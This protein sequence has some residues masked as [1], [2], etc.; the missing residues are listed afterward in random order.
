LLSDSG[1]IAGWVGAIHQA[2]Q[3]PLLGFGF[4][5]ED[6]VFI[7]RYYTLQGERPEESWIGLYLQLG[8]V[9]VVLLAALVGFILLRGAAG[10][11]RGAQ[12]HR[13]LVA[14]CAGVFLAG[15]TESLVQSFVYSAGNIA[16]L[17]LWVCAALLVPSSLGHPDEGEAG[18]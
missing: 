16:A 12:A 7:D 17:S 10:L 14:A 6:R 15:C 1:R 18:P 2:D 3:R 13:L 8:I 9:G 4:G 5:T 11:R